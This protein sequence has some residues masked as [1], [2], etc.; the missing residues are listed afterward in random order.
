MRDRASGGAG[1]IAAGI[2]AAGQHTEV[3][4]RRNAP[5]R[6]DA[7]FR[8]AFLR[9]DDNRSLL[10]RRAEKMV[11]CFFV[12]SARGLFGAQGFCAH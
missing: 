4:R 10:K 1:A 12:H 2:Y 5:L 7:V 8:A 6:P 3:K 11:M 9:S